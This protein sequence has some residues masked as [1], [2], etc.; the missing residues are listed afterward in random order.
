MNTP[1]RG[2]S[3]VRLRGFISLSLILLLVIALAAF[4]GVGWYVSQSQPT[5]TELSEP[6]AAM[7]KSLEPPPVVKTGWQ[8]YTNTEYGY[9][10]KA[11]SDYKVRRT[12]GSGHSDFILPQ[13]GD[14]PSV[15]I[16]RAGDDYCYL[17]LCEDF[18]PAKERIILNGVTWD[19]LGQTKY[20]LIQPLT[21]S[22]RTRH[23]DMTFYAQSTSKELVESILKTFK[24]SQ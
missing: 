22:Y 7:T 19:Y 14:G 9:S 5:P 13:D 17:G 21:E 12:D 11:P 20:T 10:I 4:G 6:G 1:S 2:L 3:R 23:G 8:I 24:F 15:H 16:E 18:M